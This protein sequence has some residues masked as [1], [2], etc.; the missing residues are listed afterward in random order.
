[1]EI[2]AASKE[3]VKIECI[4]SRQVDSLD[5]W[6]SGCVFWIGDFAV[7]KAVIYSCTKLLN[8]LKDMWD[9][10]HCNL[11][12][13]LL[14]DHEIWLWRLLSAPR[15]LYLVLLNFTYLEISRVC[16][17]FQNLYQVLLG[18]TYLEIL[19]IVP[20]VAF[21][22]FWT[23]CTKDSTCRW[24]LIEG[25]RTLQNHNTAFASKILRYRNWVILPST[26]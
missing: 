12:V 14:Q 15:I 10:V 13:L 8:T 5:T 6:Q 1:M 7:E 17:F 3:V 24:P 23:F 16:C 11:P 2:Q 22:K 19:C 18:F 25:N 21:F 9:N 20:C 26:L 4:Q